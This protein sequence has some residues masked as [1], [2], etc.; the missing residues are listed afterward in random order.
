MLKTYSGYTSHF[1]N[2]KNFFKKNEFLEALN[3][4]NKAIEDYSNGIELYEYRIQIYKQLIIK[5][6][7]MVQEL[8]PEDL[9]S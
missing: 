1:N 8:L 4:I 2:A 7:K 5:D 9:K 3:S 6:E